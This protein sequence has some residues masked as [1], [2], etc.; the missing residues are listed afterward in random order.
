MSAIQ[1]ARRTSAAPGLDVVLEESEETAK[2]ADDEVRLFRVQSHETNVSQE[3][4]E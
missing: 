2:E 4:N 3:K 1:T